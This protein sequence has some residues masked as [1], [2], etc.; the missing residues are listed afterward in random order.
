MDEGE[1]KNVF[2]KLEDAADILTSSVFGSQKSVLRAALMMGTLKT[3]TYVQ[4]MDWQAEI[5]AHHLEVTGQITVIIHDNASVHKS[6]LAPQYHQRW[7]SACVC[8]SFF[9]PLTVLK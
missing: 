7:H 2:D 1:S 5:A 6:H 8:T 9:S 3:P 4:L